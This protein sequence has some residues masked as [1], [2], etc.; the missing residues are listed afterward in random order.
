MGIDGEENVISTQETTPSEELNLDDAIALASLMK[1]QHEKRLVD[2]EM[3][4]DQTAQDIGRT[5]EIE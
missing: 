2:A 4:A 1:R 3:L 5:M